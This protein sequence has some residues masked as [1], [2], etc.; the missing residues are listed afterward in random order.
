MYS[1]KSFTF[2]LL[3]NFS[4]FLIE[5]L[6]LI[7]PGGVVLGHSDKAGCGLFFNTFKIILFLFHLLPS[8]PNMGGQLK[9]F[10]YWTVHSL[11]G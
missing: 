2:S 3:G 9:Y 6:G 11:R 8:V 1:I 4:I 10:Y 5:K 7:W